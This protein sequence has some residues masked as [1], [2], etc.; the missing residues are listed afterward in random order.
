MLLPANPHLFK[1]ACF[2]KVRSRGVTSQQRHSPKEVRNTH[3]SYS[4]QGNTY[5]FFREVQAGRLC[6][7]LLAPCWRGWAVAEHPASFCVKAGDINPAEPGVAEQGTRAKHHHVSALQTAHLRHLFQASGDAS[8]SA[9]RPLR[10]TNTHS[11]VIAHFAALWKFPGDSSLPACLKILT[12][13]IEH[14]LQ[15]PRKHTYTF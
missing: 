8:R 12:S 7:N 13:R 10:R 15:D 1:L 14:P 11:H 4:T 5:R 6:C 3:R 9:L 2:C